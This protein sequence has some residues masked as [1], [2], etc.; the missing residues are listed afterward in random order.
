MIESKSS[1]AARADRTI[2]NRSSMNLCFEL[3]IEAERGTTKPSRDQHTNF[4]ITKTENSNLSR[5]IKQNFLISE[6]ENSKLS[7]EIKQNFLICEI[8]NSNKI[9]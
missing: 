5:E 3:Q 9:C 7:R 8:K 6:I 2:E 4:L 1:A